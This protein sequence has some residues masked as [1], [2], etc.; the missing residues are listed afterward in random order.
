MPQRPRQARLTR[1]GGSRFDK[2]VHSTMSAFALYSTSALL[3]EALKR[4]AKQR[5][6]ALKTA[7]GA[8]AASSRAVKASCS[9]ARHDAGHCL[10]HTHT[11]DRAG[12]EASDWTAARP[13]LA[14]LRACCGG[15]EGQTS[16]CAL[17]AP[18]LDHK[19]TAYKTALQPSPEARERA[20]ESAHSRM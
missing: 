11:A 17:L 14:L 3:V 12:A 15:A 5:A 18:A 8:G 4:Q 16:P 6:E 9:A 10:L 1:E 13:A 19:S 20:L 2:A 7:S